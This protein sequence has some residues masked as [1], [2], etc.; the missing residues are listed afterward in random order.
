MTYST[1]FLV[2]N[3]IQLLWQN[4]N[5]KIC[6][7]VQQSKMNYLHILCDT[8]WYSITMTK[9]LTRV[10]GP[11]NL[12]LVLPEPLVSVTKVFKMTVVLG[13]LVFFCGCC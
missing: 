8:F 2:K 1:I 12:D 3:I 6:T 4:K 5:K 7:N 13:F 10:E 11:I 9:K